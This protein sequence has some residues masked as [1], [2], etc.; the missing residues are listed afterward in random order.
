MKRR[1]FITLVGGAA[2]WPVAARAQQPERVR[3]LGVLTGGVSES[4]PDGRARIAGLRTGLKTLGWTEGRDLRVELRWAVGDREH[5]KALALELA[6]MT[7]DVLFAGGQVALTALQQA[8]R[9]IPIVFAQT[10]D[11]IAAGVAASIARPG[12]NAT[13]FALYEQ[14]LAVKWLELLTQIAP[15]VTRVLFICDVVN[16]NGPRFLTELEAAAPTLGIR[17]SGTAVRDLTEI[18]DRID[19]FAREPN[20]G[21]IAL[22]TVIMQG[23]ELIINMAARYKL[24]AVYTYRYF[25]TS[26]GLASYGVDTIDHYRAAASYIDRILKG[27]KPGELPIQ[28]SNKYELVI[29][30]K[31]AKAL[32]LDVPI[33]LLARTDEAIE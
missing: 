12:G 28:F 13:G 20:G 32:G 26:G 23:R 3:Q 10:V 29:N 15:R 2:A 31:A 14:G 27:E 4:D 16:P 8:T 22:P 7:P 11:P 17:L 25:V 30:M 21:L 33:S 5:L 1:E 6:A 9:T 19:A 24:P 18:E